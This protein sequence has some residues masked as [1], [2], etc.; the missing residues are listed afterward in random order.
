[1]EVQIILANLA[2]RYGYNPANTSFITMAIATRSS[3]F[4]RE[5]LLILYSEQGQAGVRAELDKL[6]KDHII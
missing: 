1:V 5:H 4:D 6:K 2:P 3:V